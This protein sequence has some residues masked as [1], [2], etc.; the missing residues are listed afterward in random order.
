MKEL[1]PKVKPLMSKRADAA[2]VI[3]ERSNTIML[4]DLKNRI[5]DVNTLVA[6]LDLRTAQVL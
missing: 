5:E 3:D 1:E 2:L 6:K 4:R